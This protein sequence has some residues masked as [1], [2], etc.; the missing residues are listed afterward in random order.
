MF[1]IRKDTDSLGRCL[2][3][4]GDSTVKYCIE[5]K[6]KLRHIQC[7]CITALCPTYVGGLP[8]VILQLSDL[9]VGHV[10]IIGPP[11]L[12]GLLSNMAIFTNRRC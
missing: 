9:G 5:N 7:I 10:S 8:A 6:I 11:G 2:I 4:A 1:F 12:T 3:N